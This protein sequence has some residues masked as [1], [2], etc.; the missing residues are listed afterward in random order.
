MAPTQPR[1]G[2]AVK[3]SNQRS[4]ATSRVQKAS[5]SQ[6]PQPRMPAGLSVVDQFRIYRDRQ[7]A[8]SDAVDEDEDEEKPRRRI[9]YTK[10]QKLA[11]I[12]YATT[13]WK[14]KK[15]GSSQLISKHAAA[16]ELGIT[17]AMLRAWMKDKSSIENSLKGTRKNR[18]VK[19]GCQ[20]PEME[21]LLL[22]R[23]V[24]ARKSGRKVTNRWIF[25]HAKDIYGQL[26]PNRVIKRPGKS[27]E[28]TGFKFSLGWFS[29]F[30]KR[31][32]IAVRIPTKKSQA[33]SFSFY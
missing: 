17:P 3:P 14:V 22:T 20:E 28:Y 4:L 9:S 27:I 1:S 2:P 21:D 33:V 13:T 5:Y 18:P 19:V 31:N 8:A 15:D 6:P 24:E 10:E 16:K 32:K 11:A 12:T 26:H 23:F 25:R 7:P 29:G 30:K